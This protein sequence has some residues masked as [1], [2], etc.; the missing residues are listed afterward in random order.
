MRRNLGGADLGRVE[1]GGDFTMTA[2]ELVQ[3]LARMSTPADE[4]PKD[5]DLEDYQ[6]DLSS[7]RMEDDAHALWRLIDAAREISKKWNIIEQ[8]T[9]TLRD[10]RP[11]YESA[12]FTGC[13]AKI[14]AALELAGD[15]NE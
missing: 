12:E 9:Q 10:I 2:L 8:L 3:A 13:L 14:D 6:A 15:K 1:T 4:C 11:F 7:D 5:Q